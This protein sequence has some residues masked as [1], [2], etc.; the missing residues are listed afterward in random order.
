MSGVTQAVF[1]N[2][3]S[4]GTPYF[5]GRYGT[6][7]ANQSNNVYGVTSNASNN[8]IFAGV[9]GLYQSNGTPI[10][11]QFATVI[12]LTAAKE[13]A[14]NKKYSQTGN[15]IYI[16]KVQTDSSGNICLSGEHFA[17]PT[18][19]GLVTKLDSSGVLQWSRRLGASAGIA[20]NIG[21]GTDSS[22]NVY[23]SGYGKTNASSGVYYFYVAK[24]DSSG[25][26]QWQRKLEQGTGNNIC[27]GFFVD[28]SGNSYL[29]GYST[30]SG[31]TYGI[32]AKYNSSG[33]IQW[34][35]RFISSSMAFSS[36][37]AITADSS[38]NVYV[39]GNASGSIIIKYNSSGTIQ[40]QRTVTN[41][42]PNMI[43]VDSSGNV[44]TGGEGTNYQGLIFKYN[45][46]GTLQWQRVINATLSG[47]NQKYWWNINV[48]SNGNLGVAGITGQGAGGISNNLG[49]LAKFPNDG[50]FTG[51]Y[52]V[53]G[54][55]YTISVS[56]E[57]DSAGS[58]TDSSASLTDASGVFT[59]DS[60]TLTEATNT[61][62]I[63][64][65][66]I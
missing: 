64:L 37:S 23:I 25:T 60:T 13:T 56:T 36:G 38:G 2:Q 51:T 50:T 40:W 34:Q 14:F 45:S 15:D 20:S 33:T 66:N 17:S 47:Q 41:L 24:Y 6:T 52:T 27:Q 58:V 3:R 49:M 18:S 10:G 16:Y 54:T 43:A 4:F 55:A 21:V 62:P 48:D 12:N 30:Q 31:T 8:T 19:R 39:V 28:S 46:S 22:G 35:R 63:A 1:M 65:V 11:N 9:E 53:G 29:T 7:S 59:D 42:T 57:T 44:Y 32:V 26:I 61:T 5:F